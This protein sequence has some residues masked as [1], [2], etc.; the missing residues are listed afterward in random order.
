[1]KLKLTLFF[2]LIT[3]TII[4]NISW[5]FFLFEAGGLLSATTSKMRETAS[6]VDINH[7]STFFDPGL[8]LE[9]R[10]GFSLPLINIAAIGLVEWEAT[11]TSY[12]PD[13]TAL[14]GTTTYANDI[15]RQ[16]AG[17]T[18]QIK[19]A[20]WRIAGEYFPM[21]Q[22]VYNYS[23]SKSANPFSD[24]DTIYGD[25]YGLG[26]GYQ[27]LKMYLQFT[28]RRFIFNEGK[29]SKNNN[30]IGQGNFSKLTTQGLF[31]SAGLSL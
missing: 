25:G 26:L 18:V 14:T 10:L 6:P 19:I 15:R 11:R 30:G 24:G 27:A 9:G 5:G 20:S 7:E 29:L 21:A 17:G 31:L 3:L 4:P 1:M 23:K 12:R 22:Q 13:N 16:A 8:G 28:Y 2:S